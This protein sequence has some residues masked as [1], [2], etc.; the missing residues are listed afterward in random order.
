MR[1]MDNWIRYCNAIG[2]AGSNP[3]QYSLTY[4]TAYTILRP[5]YSRIPTTADMEIY[6]EQSRRTIRWK[7]Y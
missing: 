1:R 6:Q 7:A 4:H 5:C 3:D 2:S